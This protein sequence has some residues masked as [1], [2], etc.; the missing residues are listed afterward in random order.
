MK[1]G[2]LEKAEKTNDGAKDMTQCGDHDEEK[3]NMV[4]L[5]GF[6]LTYREKLEN[7]KT[8]KNIDNNKK[9]IKL[10]LEDVDLD[11]KVVMQH[12]VDMLKE[13]TTLYT[14]VEINKQKYKVKYNEVTPDDYILFPENVSN[15][16]NCKYAYIGILKVAKYTKKC[17]FNEKSFQA[18]QNI[19]MDF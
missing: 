6:N 3:E 8:I 10:V 2:F 16:A 11:P 12:V 5:R 18:W 7:L 17:T 4:S 14:I 13:K 9:I 1:T 19:P 15:I